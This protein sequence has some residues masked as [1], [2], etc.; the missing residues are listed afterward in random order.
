MWRRVS[1]KWKNVIDNCPLLW[2]S[3]YTPMGPKQVRTHLEKAKEAPL[4]IIVSFSRARSQDSKCIRLVAENAHRWRSVR[5]LHYFNKVVATLGSSS[6]MMLDK[7]QIQSTSIPRDCKLFSLIGPNLRKLALLLVT[8]PH[9]F[10]P[11]LGLE[12]L[13]LNSI[14][15]HVEDGTRR[16]LPLS[17]FR[18]FLQANPNLRILELNE[19]LTASPNERALQLIDL[20]KLEEATTSGSLALHMFRAEHC[21][22]VRIHMSSIKETPPLSAWTTLAHTLKGFERFLIHVGNAELYILDQSGTGGPSKI[23]VFLHLGGAENEDRRDLVYSLLGD[24]LKELAEFDAQLSGRV[25]LAL[26]ASGESGSNSDLNLQV[27]ELLQT[28]LSHSS[29]RQTRWRIPN[30]DTIRMLEPGLPY[31][32]LRAFIQARSNGDRIQPA[33]PITGIFI[34]NNKSD[35]ENRKEVLGEVLCSSG[36]RSDGSRA[37]C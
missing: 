19:H 23:G 21:R 18:H 8:I 30:L 24:I 27:L 4:D 36:E 35:Y 32:Y 7:L 10:D 33:G 25:E 5:F 13:H 29:S 6:L 14:Y 9:N 17:K 22:V 37:V 34:Q 3:I 12:E 20:P 16:T 1:R 2:S 31:N 28:P 11:T 26:F 15:E